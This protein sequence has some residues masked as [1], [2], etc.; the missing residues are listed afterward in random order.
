[1]KELVKYTTL[2]KKLVLT[3]ELIILKAQIMHQ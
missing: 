2:G 1:M 3:I